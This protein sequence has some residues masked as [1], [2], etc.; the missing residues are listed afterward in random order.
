M[1]SDKARREH[2]NQLYLSNANLCPHFCLFYYISDLQ[3]HEKSS[4]KSFYCYVF[5]LQMFAKVFHDYFSA[6]S[7]FSLLLR[8][9]SCGLQRGVW[10]NFE[11]VEEKLKCL[12]KMNGRESEESKDDNMKHYDNLIVMTNFIRFLRKLMLSTNYSEYFWKHVS[13]FSVICSIDIYLLFFNFLHF[14]NSFIFSWKNISNSCTEISTL[15]F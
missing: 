7:F 4:R 12:V 13:T 5:L 6:L 1:W 11:V 9:L 15:L 14:L 3:T 8:L 10:R 2:L